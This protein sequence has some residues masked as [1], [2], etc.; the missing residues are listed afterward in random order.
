MIRIETIRLLRKGDAGHLK[1]T[2]RWK[3][4]QT[5][6]LMG[7][8]ICVICTICTGCGERA[9]AEEQGELVRNE[10]VGEIRQPLCGQQYVTVILLSF[11]PLYAL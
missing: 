10:A 11:C 2:K 4:K 7:I 6:F 1:K 3:R 8:L 5:I 9:Q